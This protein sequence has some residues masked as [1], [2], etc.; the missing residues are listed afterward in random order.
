MKSV[1]NGKV[2]DSLVRNSRKAW[3]RYW[4]PSNTSIH[5]MKFIN[6]TIAVLII[7]LTVSCNSQSK[8]EKKATEKKVAIDS[9]NHGYNELANPS[10]RSSYTISDFNSDNPEIEN[11][12][13]PNQSII[14]TK[15][16]TK[17]LFAIWT[18]DPNGPHADFEITKKFFS[19]VD[20]DGNGDMPYELIGNHLKI[21]YNDFIQEGEIISVDKDTL[22]IKWREIENVNRY[23]KWKE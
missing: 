12:Q 20:Y 15:L 21:Y 16:D 13:R 1:L 14:N 2:P 11:I 22:K 19:V 17:K 6:T 23:V 9:V 10:N 8:A 4:Q 7:S 18:N 5:K 3:E